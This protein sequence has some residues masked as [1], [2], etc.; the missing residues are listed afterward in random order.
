MQIESPSDAFAS[1]I[2]STLDSLTIDQVCGP[3]STR[4][5]LSI[6]YEPVA[7]TLKLLKALSITDLSQTPTARLENIQ[8]LTFQTIEILNHAAN[9]SNGQSKTPDLRD[10]FINQIRSAHRNLYDTSAP[11]IALELHNQPAI[12]EQL[13]TAQ[14]TLERLKSTELQCGDILNKIQNYA[15]NTV[16]SKQSQYFSTE[17]KGHSSAA[18]A[19]F[20]GIAAAAV[21]ISATAWW[22]S[23]NPPTNLVGDS[24][25]LTILAYIPRFIILSI[26]FYSLSLCARNY[27]ASRHNYIINRHRAIALD[28]FGVF[29][30]STA[31]S[32][33]KDAIL[34][35]VSSTIFSS[36]PSGYSVDQAEPLP[37]ATAVELLQRIGPK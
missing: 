29:A 12:M 36:Q 35:Q 28:T 17:A 5:E 2:R 8:S 16:A 37:Q 30:A 27:R 34:A 23:Q 9:Y 20:G 3:A 18:W 6:P 32:K 21:I 31:D 4:H 11:A 25:P 10:N 19:W 24:L 7:A 1:R 15:T 26:A 14:S 33:V 22:A 13:G